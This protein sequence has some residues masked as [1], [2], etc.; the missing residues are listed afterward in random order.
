MQ[1]HLKLLIK[2]WEFPCWDGSYYDIQVN[3]GRSR[4]HI[5]VDISAVQNYGQKKVMLS[6]NET[7]YQ[8]G[9]LISTNS[10]LRGAATEDVK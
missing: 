8:R 1:A 9:D 5:K 4:F 10:L 2:T 3:G 7:N 6:N